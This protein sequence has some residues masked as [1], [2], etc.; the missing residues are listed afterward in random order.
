MFKYRPAVAGHE[1]ISGPFT[2]EDGAHCRPPGDTA[3]PGRLFFPEEGRSATAWP[4][5]LSPEAV[6]FH[7]PFAVGTGRTVVLHFRTAETYAPVE[8]S[9]EVGVCRPLADGS[10]RIDCRFTS[11]LWPSLLEA[12]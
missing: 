9:A 10:W 6:S 5:R 4:Q 11:K 7:L 3:H 12:L 2:L 8:V 1:A